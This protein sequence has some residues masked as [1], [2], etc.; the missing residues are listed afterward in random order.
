MEEAIM[1]D[2][3]PR[4]R[5]Q[6]LIASFAIALLAC[7]G[8]GVVNSVVKPA[9]A[10]F[11]ALYS[12]VHVAQPAV[13]GAPA[14]PL[15]ESPT[16]IVSPPQATAGFD[17]ARIAY[18]REPYKLEYFAQNRWIDPPAH[19]LAPLIVAAIAPGNTFHA[20]VTS[21]SSASGDFR[22]D[23]EIIR[24]QH[25]FTAQP[26]RV[27]FTLRASLIDDKTR[28]VL[29]A[30]EFEAVATAET[31]DPR[32]GV[33]AANGAVQTVLAELSAFCQETARAAWI[34]RQGSTDRQGKSP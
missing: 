34:A 7:G 10:P 21:P 28:A 32:G 13:T 31:A 19:M 26:S 25:E 18:V 24:L 11:P 3:T 5:P 27:R 15:I 6:G 30:R 14:R 33:V 1:H 2:E 23:T 20:V 9:G 16:L 29:A 22:L 8:C 4:M 12:L 17:S